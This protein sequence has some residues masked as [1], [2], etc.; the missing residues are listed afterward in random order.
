MVCDDS[1]SFRIVIT[2]I[3]FHE[4][5]RLAGFRPVILRRGGVRPASVFCV[6]LSSEELPCRTGQPHFR[7]SKP[8]NRSA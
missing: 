8:P 5:E 2:F 3:R 6:P 7:M 4:S 1:F